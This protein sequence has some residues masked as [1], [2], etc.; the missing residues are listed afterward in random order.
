MAIKLEVELHNSVSSVG[1]DSGDGQ[2][3]R[4]NLLSVLDHPHVSPHL[5]VFTGDGITL[6]VIQAR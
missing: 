4:R 5:T 2:Q 3:G 6:S 1:A